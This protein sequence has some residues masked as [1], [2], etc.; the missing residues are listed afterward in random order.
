MEAPLGMAQCAVTDTMRACSRLTPN[1][2][3]GDGATRENKGTPEAAGQSRNGGHS[4]REDKMEIMPYLEANEPALARVDDM[5]QCRG[6]I[7]ATVGNK[8]E[9][10]LSGDQGGNSRTSE[11]S[12]DRGEDMGPEYGLGQASAFM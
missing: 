5:V 11:A 1:T 8:R 2:N 10:A 9:A 12:A 6:E 3:L 4:G 7:V